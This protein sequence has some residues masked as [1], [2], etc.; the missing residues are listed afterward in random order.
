[1]AERVLK[2]P[3]VEVIWNTEMIDVLGEKGVTGLKLHNTETGKDSVLNLE[4]VFVAIGH[5]PNTDLFKGVLEL[6]DVGYI[7]TKG[8]STYTSIE[9]VFAAGDVQDP[10]YRQAITAAGTGCMAAMDAERW[11]EGQGH[12]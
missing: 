11:L 7:V 5:K 2:N 8:K 12:K 4:G 6:N 9:G 3:K 1:M 10:I